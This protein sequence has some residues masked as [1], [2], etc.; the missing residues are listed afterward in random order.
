MKVN[1]GWHRLVDKV[2]SGWFIHHTDIYIDWYE[3][4][5]FV[6]HW[7]WHIVDEYVHS[8]QYTSVDMNYDLICPVAPYIY[9]FFFLHIPKAVLL[10]SWCLF[11]ARWLCWRGSLPLRNTMQHQWTPWNMAGQPTPIMYP[12]QKQGKPTVNKPLI[13][14]YFWGGTWPGG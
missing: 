13:R 10:L 9:I 4:Y 1:I 5:I 14:S 12:P 7:I 2:D 11:S 3:Y 8:I 6:D